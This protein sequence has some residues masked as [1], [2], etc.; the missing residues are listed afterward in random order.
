MGNLQRF[1]DTLV[2]V[3]ENQPERS[4]VVVV[5]NQ[6]YDDPYELHREVAFVEAPASA[7]LLECFAV[8]LTASR[9]P[10]V[11]LIAGVE[12]TPGWADAALARFDD[13]DVAAVA[14]LVADRFQQHIIL[15]AGVRY[16]RGGAIS[17]I[18]AGQN[19]EGFA[20]DEH[21]LSGAELVAAFYRRE[22]LIAV[23]SLPDYGCEQVA[24]VELAFAV[25]SFGY[26]S[27]SEPECLMLA[28][29]RQFV[30]RGGWRTG[31][32]S[33]QLYRRWSAARDTRRSRLAHAALLAAETI[34]IPLRPWLLGRLAGRLFANLGFAAPREL[35]I[36]AQA[37][38]HLPNS[39]RR[40]PPFTAPKSR[41]A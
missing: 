20:V 9:A 18:G 41:A 15:S 16:T 11:H 39:S 8:G 26:R 6:P 38:A 37:A 30:R 17:S 33:E 7:S 4:E 5:T 36:G 31:V 10:I 34:Q 21:L 35:A 27:V 22:A 2:S 28:N 25:E 24:A 29:R 40:S 1:E 14:P 12:A 13:R 32:A 3:L 19:V 23:E